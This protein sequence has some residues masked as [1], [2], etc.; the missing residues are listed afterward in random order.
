MGIKNSNVFTGQVGNVNELNCLHV[1][2]KTKQTQRQKKQNK[3]NSTVRI[4]II[5]IFTELWFKHINPFI[6]AH[7]TKK[8]KM[9]DACCSFD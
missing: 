2:Y 5:F 3:I 8:K 6:Y 9:Y 4:I 1:K 7:I